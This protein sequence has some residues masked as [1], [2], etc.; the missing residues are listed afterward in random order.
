MTVVQVDASLAPRIATYETDPDPN[1]PLP[2]AKITFSGPVPIPIMG[3]GDQNTITAVYELPVN[4]AYVPL[5]LRVRIDMPSTGDLNDFAFGIAFS[6]QE[7]GLDI[8]KGMMPTLQ[9][10][11]RSTDAGQAM[12]DPSNTN[13]FSSYYQPAPSDGYFRHLFVG[14]LEG[15]VSLTTVLIDLNAGGTAAGVYQGEAT[16]LQYT[17]EQAR[18]SLQHFVTGQR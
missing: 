9:P 3:S 14:G 12:R 11:N 5:D 2:R 1:S 8:V 13:D 17:I 10:P 16:F 4:F 6:V 18:R 7:D 15:G